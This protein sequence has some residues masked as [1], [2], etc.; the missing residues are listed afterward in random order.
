MDNLLQSSKNL[1]NH[2][3]SIIRSSRVF[4][5]PIQIINSLPISSPDHL[6]SFLNLPEPSTVLMK[7]AS[8][9]LEST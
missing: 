3:Q 8:E 7:P 5:Y 1:P 9:H 2:L 6:E 4:V